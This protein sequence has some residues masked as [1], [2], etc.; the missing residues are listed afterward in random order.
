MD[1]Y[2]EE[3]GVAALWEKIGDT[4]QVLEIDSLMGEEDIPRI[5]ACCH[6]LTS[7]DIFVHDAS[8]SDF[9]AFLASY[10]DQHEYEKIYHIEPQDVKAKLL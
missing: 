5:Q 2:Y 6:K 8:S 4:L 7:I 10:G 1:D 9:T 3:V